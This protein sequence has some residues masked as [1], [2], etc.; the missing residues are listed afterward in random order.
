MDT[1]G[2]ERF[3]RLGSGSIHDLAHGS[4]EGDF[5]WGRRSAQTQLRVPLP[6]P[7]LNI[8][9]RLV[10]ARHVI[11]P[12]TATAFLSSFKAYLNKRLAYILL[13]EENANQQLSHSPLLLA[14]HSIPFNIT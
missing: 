11:P 13:C 2:T 6:R 9:R 4:P 1:S 5:G 10:R 7:Y 3:D 14:L 12:A 8:A